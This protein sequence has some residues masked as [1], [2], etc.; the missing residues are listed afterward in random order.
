MGDLSKHF[1]R[2]EFACKCGCGQDTVDAELLTELEAL[3]QHFDAPITI[4]SGNRCEEYN[5]RVG[6]ASAS[7]HLRSRA[8]DITIKGVTPLRVYT[9]LD[10][11]HKGGLGK[12]ET[13]THIDTRGSRARWGS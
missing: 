7:Q 12:Y 11:T 10:P 5:R 3:R 2:H 13:F 6:G 1:S 9:L 4:N 8:A